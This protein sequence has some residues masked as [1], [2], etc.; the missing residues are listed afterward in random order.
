MQIRYQIS[1]FTLP[2]NQTIDDYDFIRKEIKQLFNNQT[3]HDLVKKS[4]NTDKVII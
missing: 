3:I 2:V 4:E 1:L